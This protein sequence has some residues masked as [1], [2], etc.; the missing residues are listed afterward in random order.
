MPL[1]V[2]VPI[3]LQESYTEAFQTH[4]KQSME[5]LNQPTNQTNDV[6]VCMHRLNEL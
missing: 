1:F 3:L 4:G 5:D 2:F 6:K